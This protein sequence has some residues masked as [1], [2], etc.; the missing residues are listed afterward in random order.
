MIRSFLMSCCLVA[1]SQ[2]SLASAGFEGT[3]NYSKPEC[4]SGA[5][6]SG[7]VNFSGSGTVVF[8]SDKATSDA[9]GVYKLDK[10][11][12]ELLLKQNA[13]YLEVIEKQPDSPEKVKTIASTKEYM[14]MIRKFMAG[15]EF[16]VKTV[17]SY[18]VSGSVIHTEV[19]SYSS[20]FP[21]PAGSAPTSPV[22]EVA[23]SKFE[24]NANTL[25]LY[26]ATV[27]T[28]DSSTCPKGDAY[29]TVLTRAL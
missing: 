6:A 26:S 28:S 29:I 20:D 23:D 17:V 9:Q 24:L 14:E 18:S 8:T 22:G 11:Q 21:Y 12:G 25:R 13:D 16:N 27:E 7:H 10:T 19:L 15:V 3:W 4:Q 1:L 5:P 2:M